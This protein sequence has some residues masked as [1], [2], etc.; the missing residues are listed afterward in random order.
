MTSIRTEADS[1]VADRAQTFLD[2]TRINS[3]WVTTGAIVIVAAAAIY[4]FYQRSKQIEATNAERQLTTAKSSM[5]A[6]NIP[7]AQKDLQTVFSKYESTTAGV[8]AA[9]LLAQ[10]D[11]DTGKYQDG[12][13][14]LDKALGSSAANGVEATIRSLQGDGYAQMHK[15]ADAA[16]AYEQAAGATSLE[17]ERAFQLAK[18]ARAYGDGGDTAKARAAWTAILNDK[19]A[20]S[21]DAEARVRLGELTAKPVK[22]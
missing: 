14:V 2:W 13:S 20:Q 6:G 3:K 18:A 17:M 7:L 16:K 8:E 1:A 9:M 19:T 22:R 21:M 10:I 11:Y 15:M 5:Q 12:I 4:W